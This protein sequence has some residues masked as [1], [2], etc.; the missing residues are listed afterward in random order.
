MHPHEAMGFDACTHRGR[1]SVID[2]LNA[3]KDDLAAVKS[4]VERKAKATKADVD[5]LAAAIARVKAI[6]AKKAKADEAQAWLKSA[7]YSP[8]PVNTSAADTGDA[9]SFG[10]S[11]TEFKTLGAFAAH[12][13]AK[14][15]TGIK[16]ARFDLSA[17]EFKAAA[18]FT[19]N[20]ATSPIT[21]YDMNV[22]GARRELMVADL[23]GTE[24]IS[25]NAITY[26]VEGSA[27]Q[28][29][30]AVVAEGAAKPLTSWDITP[31]TKAL[32]KVAAHYKESSELLEDAPWMASSIDSRGIHLHMLA[33]ESFLLSELSATS[34]IQTGAQLDADGVFDAMTKI[35]NASGFAADGIVVSPADYQTMRLAKDKNDQYLAGGPFY[36]QYGNGTIV[37]QPGLWGLRTAVSASVPQGTAY[38][39]AFKLGGSVVTKG[40]IRVDVSNSNEDDFVKNMVTVLIEQR[41]ALALRYPAAFV[42]IT[43]A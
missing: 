29:G 36:G 26:Y 34:G 23:F 15:N 39:G 18:P 40:G 10:G 41:L 7:F 32:Q 3:A 38:V 17:P 9:A 21:D 12:H 14:A 8:Q 19:V 4:R 33:V 25:G 1:G 37:E 13:I 28:G 5:D 11:M 16:G 27:V 43:A 2:Q 31:V 20:A 24:E 42:K 30:P 22:Y 35:R 6:Q